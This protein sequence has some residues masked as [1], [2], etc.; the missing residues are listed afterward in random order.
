MIVF[1]YTLSKSADIANGPKDYLFYQLKLDAE[2]EENMQLKF[3]IQPP[4][5]ESEWIEVKNEDEDNR[6][7]T[8]EDGLFSDMNNHAISKDFHAWGPVYEY[9]ESGVVDTTEVVYN[10]YGVGQLQVDAK[11]NVQILYFNNRLLDQKAYQKFD[12]S[13][14]ESI[15]RK[16][17]EIRHYGN[18]RKR[19]EVVSKSDIITLGKYVTFSIQTEAP[20]E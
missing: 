7:L 13:E 15:V 5:E 6:A 8:N 18:T 4:G 1:S 3:F 9:N 10:I 11:W 12:A 17:I 14:I 2:D 19:E 16:P 20:T